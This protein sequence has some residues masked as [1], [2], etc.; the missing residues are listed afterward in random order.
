MKNKMTLKKAKFVS[1]I[2]GSIGA[3]VMLGLGAM[4]FMGWVVF[5]IGFL[6]V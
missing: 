2:L 3:L 6:P 4:F 5:W 1:T